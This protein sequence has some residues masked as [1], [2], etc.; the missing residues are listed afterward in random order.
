M[1]SNQV[2]P[3]KR[4]SSAPDEAIGD[5]AKEIAG[6]AELQQKLMESIVALSWHHILSGAVGPHSGGFFRSMPEASNRYLGVA[7]RNILTAAIAPQPSC[8]FEDAVVE[9]VHTFY[10]KALRD[11]PASALGLTTERNKRV[12]AN[13]E[14]SQ[15]SAG[16]P[17]ELRAVEADARV[18]LRVAD[19]AGQDVDGEA[20]AMAKELITVGKPVPPTL[21][22][23]V[24][25]RLDGVASAR[26][27]PKP[28]T[29]SKRDFVIVLSVM[30]LQI[31][32]F[33]ETRNFVA[34]H[35]DQSAHSA[36]S[37]VAAMASLSEDAIVK[38][39]AKWR[40][41]ARQ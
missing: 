17:D 41:D 16:V 33:K 22:P 21:V 13:Y 8:R 34:R 1:N 5:P 31:Y 19:F 39:L 3:R 32:G 37:R 28:G 38:I 18:R 36:C 15:S 7:W 40:K 11:G 12:M 25:N 2:K 4:K 10:A 20:I 6:R 29:N 27:G 23:F 35:N 26:K 9:A 24:V 14:A 30:A